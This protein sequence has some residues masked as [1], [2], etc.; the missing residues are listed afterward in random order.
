MDKFAP[1]KTKIGTEYNQRINI[2]T[3]LNIRH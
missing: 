1:C 2:E 3:E